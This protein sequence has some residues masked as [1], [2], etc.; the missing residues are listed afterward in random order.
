MKCREPRIGCHARIC[1]RKGTRTLGYHC[2]VHVCV[3]HTSKLH[4]VA[5][6]RGKGLP[7]VHVRGHSTPFST[8]QDPVVPY[9]RVG[10]PRGVRMRAVVQGLG[11]A[12]HNLRAALPGS[13]D[14]PT[15][16]ARMRAH[17]GLFCFVLFFIPIVI[18]GVR[19]RKPR[20]GKWK[21]AGWSL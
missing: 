12:I 15:R 19:K 2:P 5:T 14:R 13:T 10:G 18:Q 7:R 20:V 11:T 1:E 16:A 17:V 21:M 9:S 6:R 3:S 4:H 8:D